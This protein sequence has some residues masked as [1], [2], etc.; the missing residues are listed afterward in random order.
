ME[1]LS[2]TRCTEILESEPVGHV[3]VSD[4]DGPY[5][6]PVSFV[7]IEGA[8]YFRTGAG[9]R[10]RA[11]AENPRVCFEVSR[12]EADRGSWES[13]VGFGS[14]RLVDDDAVAQ[15]VVQKLFSKYSEILGTPLS[16][17]GP[18]PLPEFAAIVRIGFEEIS[19][20]SSGTWF[21]M[22]TRPG[23]L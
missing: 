11:I 4:D 16:R 10:L 22:P 12:Y 15:R 3:A 13:V 17:G 23:R 1:E 6:T 5:V 8:G 9:R 20:R 2:L 14:A 18:R 21:S 7:I 19:G